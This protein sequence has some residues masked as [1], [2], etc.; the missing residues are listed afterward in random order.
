MTNTALESNPKVVI[1]PSP[2][3]GLGV[4]AVEAIAKGELI[5]ECPCLPLEH[6]YERLSSVINHY[7]Y[8]WPL[9]GNGRA[10]VWGSASIFNHSEQ[11]NASWQT[12]DG[13]PRYVFE[14]R[15]TIAAGEEI[16]ID[17]GREYWQH[18]DG[19]PPIEGA[20]ERTLRDFE[21]AGQHEQ[22]ND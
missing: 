7:L 15:R 12:H 8:E 21:T 16:F 13:P 14:A 20:A 9:N 18:H 1:A 5:E 22:P 6:G 10:V 11:A 19:Y 3:H 4:F 2:V 17:Y